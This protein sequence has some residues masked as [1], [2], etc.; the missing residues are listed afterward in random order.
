MRMAFGHIL[1]RDRNSGFYLKEPLI[2]DNEI[3]SDFNFTFID[4]VPGL[5]KHPSSGLSSRR[6]SFGYQT[7]R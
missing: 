3:L 4:I 7:F 1:L 5:T 2:I 6:K